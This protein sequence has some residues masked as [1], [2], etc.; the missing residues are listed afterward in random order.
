MKRTNIFAKMMA[1]ITALV[2]IITVIIMCMETGFALNKDYQFYGLFFAL[3]MVMTVVF[4]V[5]KKKNAIIYDCRPNSNL[6]NIFNIHCEN[7][8]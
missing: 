4:V 3:V 6:T 1:I 8:K 7:S 5:L 2:A